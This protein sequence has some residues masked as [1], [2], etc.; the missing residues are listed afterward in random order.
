MLGDVLH[1]DRIAQVRLVGAVFAH[2]LGVRDAR[3]GRGRDGLA[4]SEL[5]EHAPYDRLHRRENILLFD[6]AHLDV[7]LVELAR[8]TISARI[9]V[10]KTWRDLKI[11]VEA[12]HHQELLVLLG[13]LRQRIERARMQTRR[14]EE[15][16]RAFGARGGE[17][18]R[19]EL[20]KPLPLHP[21]AKRINDLPTQHDVLVKFLAP[22]IKEPVPEPRIF[23]IGLVA[24][25]RQRQVSG[26][27]EHF[28]LADVNLDQPRRHFGVFSARRALA[29]LAVDTDH[30]FRPQLLGLTESGRIRIDHALG[31][32]VV[33]A[34]IDEQHAAVIAD[35]MAP[36]RKPNVGAVLGEGQG[37]AGMG[38]VAVHD[39]GLFSR[40]TALNRGA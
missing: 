28:D 22:E 21:S 4:A 37:A 18:R 25:H 34:Q 27:P 12:R 15:V 11:A 24:E 32:A 13:R 8:Q 30:E 35:A 3:P 36:A 1:D 29:N 5:L 17:D 23:G 26:W 9:L 33:V 16:A 6:E 14:H 10:A 39:R 7:E 38:A 20:E 31:Q 19:L 2:R 40:Q